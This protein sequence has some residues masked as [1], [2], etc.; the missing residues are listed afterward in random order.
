MQSPLLSLTPSDWLNIPS[1][2]FSRDGPL[3]SPRRV[4]DRRFF[5]SPFCPKV[6][7][8]ALAFRDRDFF[9]STW[10]LSEVIS[11]FYFFP[12]NGKRVP[13]CLFHYRQSTVPSFFSGPRSLRNYFFF[14]LLL[15]RRRSAL[16]FLSLP[17]VSSF[18]ARIPLVVKRL[19]SIGSSPFSSLRWS[20]LEVPLSS[21]CIQPSAVPFSYVFSKLS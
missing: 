14:L 18:L 19:E 5:F 10:L 6:V 8:I 11:L 15:C 21:L 9:F 3:P 12:T 13:L 1:L 7:I 2:L 17:L 16:S 4:M 20:R